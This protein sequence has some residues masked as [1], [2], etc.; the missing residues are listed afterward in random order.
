[1]TFVYLVLAIVAEVIATSALKSSVGFTRPLPSIMVVVGYGVAFY[2]L[3]LVLRTLPVGIAYAIWA[4]L[5][6]VLVTLV[7]IVVFGEKPDLPAVIGI[8]LIVAGV[9]ILQ[10][11]SKMNVH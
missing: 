7:G 3:S 1:M 2:L 6:I 9:V 11:F 8:S 5:G 4:G 10:V